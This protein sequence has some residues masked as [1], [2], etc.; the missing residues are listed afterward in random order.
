MNRQDGVYT[1]DECTCDDPTG[2]YVCQVHPKPRACGCDPVSSAPCACRIAGA[3]QER[4]AI[5]AFILDPA[6][7]AEYV[8]HGPRAIAAIASAIERGEHLR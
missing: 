6:R 8:M 7:R 3:A 1:A 2:L 5:V 4:V